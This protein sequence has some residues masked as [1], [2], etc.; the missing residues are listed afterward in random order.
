MDLSTAYMGLALRNPL[1]ASP[2]PL[3]YTV[4][5]V[6]RLA[7]AGVGAVVLFSLFEEQVREQAA[8]DA[9]IVDA[10][11]DS[12]GEALDYLPLVARA[13]IGPNSYLRLLE[14]AGPATRAR[15]RMPARRRSS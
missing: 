5:G 3:S 4:E 14:Q 10:S 8:R 7:D 6:Q 9:M 1:V 12:F 2:S 11:A 13:D 15:W